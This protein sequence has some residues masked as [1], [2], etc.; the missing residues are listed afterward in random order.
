[1]SVFM[2]QPV[3]GNNVFMLQPVRGN[4]VCLHAAASE[5]KPFIVLYSQ[6]WTDCSIFMSC[7]HSLIGLVFR[8][9]IDLKQMLS[10]TLAVF[11]VQPVLFLALF[12]NLRGP[13]SWG[14]F[15]HFLGFLSHF[16]GFLF[17]FPGVPF[18]ISWV[19]FPISWGSFSHFLGFLF[20]GNPLSKLSQW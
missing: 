17:P 20:P 1:M 11:L 9:L 3:R 6:L 16:L 12:N 4:N 15:S 10:L 8:V 7:L 18:P 13:I 14:S 19:P 2:L 5:G